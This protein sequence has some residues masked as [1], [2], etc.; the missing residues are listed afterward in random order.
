MTNGTPLRDAVV[1]RVPEKVA[2]A[3]NRF[4]ALEEEEPNE[5]HQNEFGFLD[6]LAHRIQM[7]KEVPQA[8]RK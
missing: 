3:R 5:C 1:R 2:D 6:K 4:G 8:Q 7:G